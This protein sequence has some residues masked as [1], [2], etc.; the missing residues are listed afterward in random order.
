MCLWHIKN[1]RATTNTESPNTA[2]QVATG[3]GWGEIGLHF[4]QKLGEVADGPPWL[5]TFGLINSN[6]V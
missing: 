6:Y 3:R 1:A 4:L 2:I 5:F